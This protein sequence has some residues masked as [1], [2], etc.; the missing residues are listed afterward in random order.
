MRLNRRGVARV[1]HT[2]L[3]RVVEVRRIVSVVV[4]QETR[5]SGDI[6]VGVQCRG[7]GGGE[8]GKV[9][10]RRQGQGMLQVVVGN[11][12]RTASL[13]LDRNKL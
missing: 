7:F 11:A 1:G 8:M 4:V 10:N 6:V 13:G 3:G 9:A 5:Y 2:F 12:S